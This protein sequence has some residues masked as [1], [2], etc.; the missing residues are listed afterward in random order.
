MMTNAYDKNALGKQERKHLLINEVLKGLHQGYPN[1]WDEWL[2]MAEHRLRN[3]TLL[4]AGYT[5]AMMVFGRAPKVPSPRRVQQIHQKRHP[6]AEAYISQLQ[7]A[8]GSIWRD[9]D[10]A[11]ILEY[12]RS[13]VKMDAGR[14]VG[15]VA[16]GDYVICYAL[17]ASDGTRRAPKAQPAVVWALQSTGASAVKECS[18]T[19]CGNRC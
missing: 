19:P 6:R 11:G 7:R 9:V 4:H 16:V 14:K 13:F 8:L 1:R 5:P 17:P 2:P 15:T 3:T 10:Q 18:H 12:Q